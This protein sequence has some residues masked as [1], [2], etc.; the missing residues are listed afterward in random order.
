MLRTIVI[1][2]FYV[3]KIAFFYVFHLFCVFKY[4]L[5]KKIAA[6]LL[7]YL[8]ECCTPLVISNLQLD[9]LGITSESRV[10]PETKLDKSEGLAAP[11]HVFKCMTVVVRFSISDGGP[12][13]Y[14]IIWWA[15]HL[16]LHAAPIV[17]LGKVPEGFWFQQ[18]NREHHLFIVYQCGKSMT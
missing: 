6:H 7:L 15:D 14:F 11:G 16:Q 10:L 8:S 3:V 5:N 1:Y 13:V 18:H 12:G 17:P 4:E 2:I 9:L